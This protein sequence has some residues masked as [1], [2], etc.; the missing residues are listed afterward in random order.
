[1]GNPLTICGSCFPS[2][3][4][5]NGSPSHRF[6]RPAV[7]RE[8]GPENRHKMSIFS[9]LSKLHKPYLSR[10]FEDFWPES[11]TSSSAPASGL[12]AVARASRPVSLL[13]N[14]KVDLLR[15]LRRPP[16]KHGASPVSPKHLTQLSVLFD[17]WTKIFPNYNPSQADHPLTACGS[18]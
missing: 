11:C 5:M 6:E 7:N 1:V 14:N 4:G 9:M 2:L 8:Y 18:A 17:N 13:S 10:S 3:V 15:K 12:M 16:K